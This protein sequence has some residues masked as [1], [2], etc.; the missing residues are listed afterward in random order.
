ME[1]QLSKKAAFLLAKILATASCRNSKTEPSADSSLIKKKPTISF[2]DFVMFPRCCRVKG[3][4]VFF[5]THVAE[6]ILVRALNII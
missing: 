5:V 2:N 3:T 1:A 4:D 6:G